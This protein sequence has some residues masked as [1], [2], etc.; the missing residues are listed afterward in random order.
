VYLQGALSFIQS[1]LSAAKSQVTDSVQSATQ[2]EA[3]IEFPPALSKAV[4]ST[5]D[6]VIQSS[7]Q[8]TNFSGS[9]E[10]AKNLR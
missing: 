4:F 7:N 5:L 10:E 1:R 6:N 2:D 3:A 9:T 8:Q